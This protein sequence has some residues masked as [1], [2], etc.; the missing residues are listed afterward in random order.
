[1]YDCAFL[2]RMHLLQ[3]E[4]APGGCTMATVGHMCEVHLLLKGM[5]DAD[6]EIVKLEEKVAKIDG[7]LAK[8][9]KT[10]SI[11]NYQEKVRKT[12]ELHDILFPLR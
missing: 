7:Q 11:E 9:A 8:L 12:Q 1:M 4:A 5:V 3:S 6:K 10:M 2:H